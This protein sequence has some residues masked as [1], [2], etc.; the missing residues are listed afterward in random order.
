MQVKMLDHLN[1]TVCSVDQTADWYRRVFGFDVVEEGTYRGRRWSILQ[2]E[3]AV[4]CVYE[5]PERG[6]PEL[7]EHG[8]HGVAHFGLRIDDA[9]EWVRTVEREHVDVLYDGPVRWPRSTSWYV[10]DPNG[11]EIEVALWHDGYPRFS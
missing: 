10:S 9:A 7:A 1:M 2:S 5:H 6:S 3:D 8:S 11:Y 4:L